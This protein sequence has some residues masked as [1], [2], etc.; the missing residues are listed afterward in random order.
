MVTGGTTFVSRYVAEYYLKKD[1]KVYV[2]NRNTK[3][4]SNGVILIE[5]DRK[6]IGEKLRD[7]HFDI[8]FD[9]TAYNEDDINSL[10]NALGSFNDYIM[11]SSSAVYP[12]YLPQPF[13]SPSG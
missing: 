2:L 7:Y 5:A 11:I 12:E 3:P 6:N 10:L 4:Q 9:I 8:V 1:Y 13:C